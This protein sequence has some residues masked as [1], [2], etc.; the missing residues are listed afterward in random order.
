MSRYGS[1]E[2]LLWGKVGSE[3]AVCKA[4]CMHGVCAGGDEQHPVSVG[5]YKSVCQ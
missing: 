3:F 5:T 2:A 4:D 1:V